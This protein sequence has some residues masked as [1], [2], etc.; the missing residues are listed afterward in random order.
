MGVQGLLWKASRSRKLT[1]GI[2]LG[3]GA[4]VRIQ[5]FM[6]CSFRCNNHNTSAMCSAKLELQWLLQ[7]G[8][9]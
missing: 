1:W 2:G 4:W 9:G 5:L 7:G 3:V 8:D 6:T